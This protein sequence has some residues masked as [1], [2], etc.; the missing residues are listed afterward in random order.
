MTTLMLGWLRC[1]ARRE[2]QRPGTAEEGRNTTKQRT[3]T[4]NTNDRPPAP[5]TDQAPDFAAKS[6]HDSG[7]I[8][9]TS[10][11]ALRAHQGHLAS[12]TRTQQGHHQSPL[13]QRN[14]VRRRAVPHCYTDT[15]RGG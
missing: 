8:T 2:L 12:T 6:T 1:D 11:A 4:I 9:P 3:A 15:T 10:T 14:P 13:S 7:R 5:R